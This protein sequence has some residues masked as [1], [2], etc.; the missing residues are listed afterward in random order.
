MLGCDEEHR[1]GLLAYKSVDSATRGTRSVCRE[2]LFAGIGAVVVLVVIFG[3]F[4]LRLLP[5]SGKSA[6]GRIAF[7]SDRDGDREVYVMNADCSGLVQLMDNDSDD[8]SLAW[9]LVID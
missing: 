1:Y 7:Q 3:A 2:W 6:S 9:S 4:A 5:L 8:R